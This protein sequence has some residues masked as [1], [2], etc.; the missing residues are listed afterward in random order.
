LL[1]VAVAAET[2]DQD[3]Q[4]DLVVAVLVM[5]VIHPEKLV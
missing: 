5:S 2:M 4:V 1:A 3:H